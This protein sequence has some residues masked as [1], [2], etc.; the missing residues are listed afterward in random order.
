MKKPSTDSELKI[1][2]II[3]DSTTKTGEK[4]N[5]DEQSNYSLWK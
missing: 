4:G 3:K 5:D 2:V 1:N